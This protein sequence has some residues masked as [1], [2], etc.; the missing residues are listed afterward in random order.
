MSES[1]QLGVY[2]IDTAELGTAL[3]AVLSHYFGVSRTIEKL[4]RT[5]AWYRSSFAL[6]ELEVTLDD[7]VLLHILFKD[8]NLQALSEDGRLAKPLF[9]YHPLREI[10][11]YR[12][13]LAAHLPDT[14]I[15]YGAVSDSARDRYWLFLEKVA[16]VALYEVGLA[17]WQRVAQWLATMHKHFAQQTELG[18]LAV[19]SHL[20]RYDR[21]FY[22][23][24]PRRAQ[25]FLRHIEP[26][27]PADALERFDRLVASY[28]QVVERLLA[29]PVT[30]IHGEF[31]A[32]NVLV[33]ETADRLRVCPVDWE[34][35]AL[36]PGLLDLAA[37][38][39]GNWTEAEKSLMALAY[40]QALSGE[41]SWSPTIDEFLAALN[42]CRLHVAM[43]WLGWSAEWRPP[44]NQAQNWL[45]EALQ[46]MEWV[47]RTA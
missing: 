23:V 1:S 32:A 10:E 7:G 20:L 15:C 42:C 13:I 28:D 30:F 43:Q 3:E 26:P 29:L 33:Q 35:A 37:L 31:Y 11:T 18:D 44:P 24:W 4:Q 6:E 36:G 9:L 40:H 22:W 27:P 25:I 21:D 38:I 46:V 8:V 45:D 14:A 34:M 47:M 19:T 16:G 17:T 41:G 39:A 5:P 12:H 2:E